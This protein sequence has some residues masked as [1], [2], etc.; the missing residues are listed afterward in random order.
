MAVIF[1]ANRQGLLE[2][3]AYAV[4]NSFTAVDGDEDFD[5]SLTYTYE[6]MIFSIHPNERQENF[7]DIKNFQGRKVGLQI[8]EYD[9]YDLNFSDWIIYPDLFDKATTSIST[10]YTPL[11]FAQLIDD[12]AYSITLKE[13]PEVYNNIP[14]LCLRNVESNT[15]KLY[16]FEDLNSCI[17]A[18]NTYVTDLEISGHILDKSPLCFTFDDYT[19]SVH[20]G[21]ELKKFIE[22]QDIVNALYHKRIENIRTE[23]LDVRIIA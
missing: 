13:L 9:R 23:D 1:R 11:S 12:L 22:A 15:Y 6:D 8:Y 20:L 7:V 4:N 21:S 16:R 17:T 5:S 18:L 3:L 10:S 2:L 19:M 14:Y